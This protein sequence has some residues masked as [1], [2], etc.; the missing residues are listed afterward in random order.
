MR[1]LLP[2]VQVFWHRVSLVTTP[3]HKLTMSKRYSAECFCAQI[4]PPWATKGHEPECDMPCKGNLTQA[5][6]GAGR[7]SLYGIASKQKLGDDNGLNGPDDGADD[8]DDE[9]EMIKLG[10]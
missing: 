9:I 6:G 8:R 1:G 5:C 7:L 10:P 2:G 3:N 4:L